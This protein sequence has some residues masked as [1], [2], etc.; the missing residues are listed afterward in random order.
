[1]KK[2]FLFVCVMLVGFVAANAQFFSSESTRKAGERMAQG[3]RAGAIAILDKAIEKHKDLL[4]AYQM[5]ANL[6]SMNGDLAGAIADYSAALEINPNDAKIYERRAMFRMFKRD[7]AGALKDLDAAIANGLKTERVYEERGSVKRD[8]GELEGAIADY[9]TAL[10][11]NPN[12]ASAHNGL[13]F[14]LERKG[15]LDAAIAHLQEFLNGYE[16]NRNGKLPSIK[17]EVLTGSS[18]S[19]KR[20]GKEKDGVQAYMEGIGFTGNSSPEKMEQILNLT[21]AYANL[22][23]MYAK[24]NEFD[25]ALENYE[26]GLKIR[27]DDPDIH[28]LRSEIRIKKGDLQGVIEDLTVVANSPQGAP[29]RHLDK[30]LLLTLLGKDDEAEKEFALHL[31][32]FPVGREYLN[33]RIEEAK[34]LRSQQ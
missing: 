26:K 11:L 6:R 27:K 5:R 2:L 15:D 8:M 30:G 25:K 21:L 12:L 13:A 29:D 16:G 34:K 18:I 19:I 7:S 23:R 31:Q 24:K 4:E 9:Q 28:K 22:G 33:K 20:E 32:M 17:G 14:T 10:A 3:D 1:M